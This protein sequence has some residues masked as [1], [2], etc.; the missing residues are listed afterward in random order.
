MIGLDNISKPFP[1]TS[2]PFNLLATDVLLFIHLSITWPLTAGLLSI[3]LPL[4]P[5]G[6]GALDELYFSWR[7]LEGSWGNV[8]ADIVHTILF[9]AQ[10]A[11]FVSLVCF[12]LMGVPTALYFGYIAAFLVGNFYFCECFLNGPSDQKF[13]A[14]K[15]YAKNQDDAGEKWVSKDPSH[16]GEKWVLINGVAVG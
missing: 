10:I 14:G 1:Y 7:D 5:C 8:K 2:N 13:F 16:E 3:V 11:F 6:S 9:V 15:E 4:Q 12:L